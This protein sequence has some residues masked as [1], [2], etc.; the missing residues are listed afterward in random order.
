MI[1]LMFATFALVVFMEKASVDLLVE[2]RE[3]V[4]RRLRVEAYSALET[5]LAV[6]EDFR[7]AGQ[8]LRS[9]AEGW[10]D[11]LGFAGYTPSDGRTIQINFD[12]ESGKISLPRANAVILTNLFKHWGIVQV[13]AEALADALVGWMKRDHIY[14]SAVQPNYDQGPIPFEVTGVAAALVGPLASAQ[15]SV[16]LLATYDTDY[17][18]LKEESFGRAVEVLRAAGHE[19]T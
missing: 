2:Q 14:S 13:D 6:L 17:L 4:T 3:V 1:T 5:T 7:E 11:P 18:L 16:F 8:G 15:I 9:P 10:N 12:D 19:T